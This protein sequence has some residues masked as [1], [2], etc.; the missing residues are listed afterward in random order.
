LL[1]PRELRP[2]GV[3][4]R[5]A[6]RHRRA[7]ARQDT[8]LLPEP[9][10]RRPGRRGRVRQGLRMGAAAGG[11]TAAEE[12]EPRLH[13]P[14]MVAGVV[15][16]LAALT[17][18]RGVGA[19]EAP[20][21]PVLGTRGATG[22]AAGTG[23]PGGGSA[24]PAALT[25]AAAAA[26]TPSRGARAVRARA[27]ASPRARSAANHAG[28]RRCRHGWAVP[29][30]RP[31]QRPWPTCSAEVFPDVS[32]NHHRAAGVGRGQ[33]LSTGNRR[34]VRGFPSSRHAARGHGHAVAQGGTS[35]CNASSVTRVH[36]RHA[37][38]RD[39]RSVNRTPAMGRASCDCLGLS[40]AHHTRKK[41]G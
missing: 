16:L 36:S 12:E 5:H 18:R 29:G 28:P 38:G 2:A 19:D 4:G 31:H 34:A 8:A 26:E 9:A 23:G 21:G 13:E 6:D 10:P 41:A 24:A 17:C 15:L 7:R 40:E 14:A 39:G 11:V 30:P 35:G 37:I 22:A 32:I 3:L 25:G 20:C 33:L 27:G 1:L